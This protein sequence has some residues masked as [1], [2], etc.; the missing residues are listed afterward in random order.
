MIYKVLHDLVPALSDLAPSS[1]LFTPHQLCSFQADT[2]QL[3]FQGLGICCTPN[4]GT[5]ITEGKLQK[6]LM[7]C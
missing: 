7:L 1:L 3:L 4:V 6:A 5:R 2:A